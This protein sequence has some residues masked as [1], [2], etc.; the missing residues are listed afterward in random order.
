MSKFSSILPKIVL[1]VLMILSVAATVIAFIGGSVDPTAEYKEPAHLDVLLCWMG[2]IAGIALLI[3]LGFALVQLIRNFVKHP[4][5]ALK[6]MVG[7]LLL[8]ALLIVSF[9]CFTGYKYLNNDS[10]PTFDG[11]ITPTMNNLANM[12]I[13]S[14]GVLALVAVILIV[15]SG[16]FKRKVK[17]A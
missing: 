17:D 6:S 3:T 7:I 11:V 14:I 10:I 2:I 15:F 13:I 1:W 9:F 5:S 16:A 12:S 8:F 4:L